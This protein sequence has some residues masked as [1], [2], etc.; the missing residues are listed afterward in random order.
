MEEKLL[1]VDSWTRPYVR[2]EVL[3]ETKTKYCVRLFEPTFLKGKHVDKNAV[4]LV[5]KYSV[6]DRTAQSESLGI[7]L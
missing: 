7:S 2:V 1:A 6:R 5:P 4:V 3:G